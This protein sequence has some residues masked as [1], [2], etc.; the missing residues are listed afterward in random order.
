MKKRK[1]YYYGDKYSLK[2]LGSLPKSKI[3]N[4]SESEAND[5]ASLNRVAVQADGDRLPRYGCSN[6]GEGCYMKRKMSSPA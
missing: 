1:D 2:K 5:L 6:M 4:I 3:A